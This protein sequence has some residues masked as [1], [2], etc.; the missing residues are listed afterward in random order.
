MKVVVK[1]VKHYEGA[2]IKIEIPNGPTIIVSLDGHVVKFERGRYY[3]ARW[4]DE[5]EELDYT[6]QFVEKKYEIEL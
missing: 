6:E 1:T 2:G 3:A 5:G 4:V